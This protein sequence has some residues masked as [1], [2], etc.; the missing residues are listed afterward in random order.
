M[1]FLQNIFRKLVRNLL[2]G[3]SVEKILKVQICE[4]GVMKNA[5]E[6]WQDMY[7]NEPPWKGGQEKIIPLNLPAVISSDGV[8]D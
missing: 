6:L 5:I 8:S 2:P 3:N 7:K 1:A 4:S